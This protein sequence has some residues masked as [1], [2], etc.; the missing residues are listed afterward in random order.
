M[1]GHTEYQRLAVSGYHQLLPGRFAVLDV[2]Q[3]PNVMDFHATL[4]GPAVFA[5][6]G[7]QALHD[8]RKASVS[9]TV[10]LR[11]RVALPPV[12]WLEV[13]QSKDTVFFDLP[14]YF[15][16]NRAMVLPTVVLCLFANVL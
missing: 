12:C 14:L 16:V 15:T 5:D 3:P 6:L 4:V 7:L 13:L 2:L 11:V 8:L 1:A 9:R 10:G